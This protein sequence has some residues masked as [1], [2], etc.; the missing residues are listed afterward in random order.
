MSL[1]MELPSPPGSA[2]A[3]RLQPSPTAPAARPCFPVTEPE[4]QHSA[5]RRPHQPPPRAG[6]PLGAQ[7]LSGVLGRCSLNS[8]EL[9]YAEQNVRTQGPAKL[10]GTAHRRQAWKR[11]GRA[12]Q[13]HCCRVTPGPGGHLAFSRPSFIPQTRTEDPVRGEAEQPR[14]CLPHPDGNADHRA[15]HCTRCE[16]LWG[17]GAVPGPEHSVGPQHLRPL[18][19]LPVTLQ[20]RKRRQQ[21]RRMSQGH[22]AGVQ[23]CWPSETIS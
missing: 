17:R 7:A 6:E 2:R 15:G 16:T 8:A 21:G 4:P 11:V 22:G 18:S 12:L 1:P 14:P 20:E 5:V 13:P 9:S 3:S 10:S 19:A 23:E